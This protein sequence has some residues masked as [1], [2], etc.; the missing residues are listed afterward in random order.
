MS[1]PTDED[2]AREFKRLL[3]RLKRLSPAPDGGQYRAGGDDLSPPA[4]G[5]YIYQGDIYQG[6]RRLPPPLAMPP[7]PRSP[8]V[9]PWLYVLATAL[10]TIVVAVL[11]VVITLGVMRQEP[12]QIEGEVRERLA[13][14]R[15]SLGI[16]PRQE[17]LTTGAFTN[18]PSARTQPALPVPAVRVRAIG[19]PEEPLRLEP[20]K[21]ARF[22]FLIEPEQA[23]RE[24]YILILSGLPNGT[25]LT[26]AQRISS[27]S[28]LLTPDARPG[29]R[30]PFPSGRRCS[31]RSASSSGAPMVPSPRNPG[32]G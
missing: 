24:S 11:A 10:N 7:V 19:S 8:T 1:D 23:R 32:P 3:E 21:P 14:V 28:W 26:G 18:I 29:S 5:P 13:K 30:Y 17:D 31:R 2:K 9:S 16:D 27:D 20:Q 12:G 15:S 6:A 22:P 25:S 4:P